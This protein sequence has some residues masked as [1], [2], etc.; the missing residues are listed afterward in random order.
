M[1]FNYSI[2]ADRSLV[3]VELTG[4]LT[5][6]ELLQLQGELLANPAFDPAMRQ[7]CDIRSGDVSGVST[8]AVKLIA[9]R[10]IEGMVRGRRAI[11][12]SPG[13]CYGLSRMFSAYADADEDTTEVFSEMAEAWRWIGIES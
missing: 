12:A 6:D 13:L 9:S 5:G 1:P 3:V 4:S 2:D 8:D 10:S 7:I 11:V